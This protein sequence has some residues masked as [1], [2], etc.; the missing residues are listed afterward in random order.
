MKLNKRQ[1]R[2]KSSQLCIRTPYHTWLRTSHTTTTTTTTTTS[3]LAER[4]Y[5]RVG[6]VLLPDGLLGLRVDSLES[7][8]HALQ[9]GA[10]VTLCVPRHLGVSKTGV[11][12]G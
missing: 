9:A 11:G 6:L 1:T 7:G 4:F 10:H 2:F 8:V 5:S 3:S 12:V